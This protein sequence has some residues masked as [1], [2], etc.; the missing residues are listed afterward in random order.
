MNSKQISQIKKVLLRAAVIVGAVLGLGILASP[1]PASYAAPDEPAVTEVSYSMADKNNAVGA[2]LVS[3]L[4]SELKLTVSGA[5]KLV[6]VAARYQYTTVDSEGNKHKVPDQPRTVP[7][8][9]VRQEADGDN[10]KTFRL[11]LD[12]EG[13]YAFGDIRFTLT[14]TD[15]AQKTTKTVDRTLSS[16]IAESKSSPQN[17]SVKATESLQ[18]S[19]VSSFLL[20]DTD[21]GVSLNVT[22]A[23]GKTVDNDATITAASRL[24][25]A[26]VSA[27]V[28]NTYISKLDDLKKAWIAKHTVTVANNDTGAQVQ[29]SGD[30][31]AVSGQQ[32]GSFTVTAQLSKAKEK[33]GGS[34][35]DAAYT[36]K[37]GIGS[38]IGKTSDF[39][40]DTGTPKISAEVPHAEAGRDLAEKVS[41]RLQQANVLIRGSQPKIRITVN[42]GGGIDLKSVKVT[43]KKADSLDGSPRPADASSW[44]QKVSSTRRNRKVIY[45]LTLRDHGLYNLSDIAI[46]A[47]NRAGRPLVADPDGQ[48]LSNSVASKQYDAILVNNGAAESLKPAITVRPSDGNAQPK[49]HNGVKYYR[50][51]VVETVTV[52]DKWIDA[53]RQITG[54]K[55]KVTT[56]AGSADPQVSEIPLTDF[57]F[58]SHDNTVSAAYERKVSDEGRYHVSASLLEG[59]NDEGIEF[60]IDHTA[61]KI[62]RMAVEP[63]G[64]PVWNWLFSDRPVKVTFSGMADHLSGID[65][66]ATGFTKYNGHDADGSTPKLN[67]DDDT[68]SFTLEKNGDR[69]AFADTDITIT[70]FAGNTATFKLSDFVKNDRNE[71][72]YA[73]NIAQKG[74]RGVIVQTEKPVIAVTYDNNSVRNGKYYASGR[75]AT[76][77]ITDPVFDLIVQNDPQRAIVTV[78]HDG[79]STT[80]A[81]EKFTQVPGRQDMWTAQVKCDSDGEWRLSAQLTD[82]SG[83]SADPYETEFIVDATKPSLTLTFDNNR[84][85]NGNYYNANRTATVTVSDRNLDMG[86]THIA[87]TA[88]GDDGRPL[89]AP[90]VSPWAVKDGGAGKDR[91]YTATVTF[92][93]EEHYSISAVSADLAGNASEKV[94]EPEFIIDKTM[95]RLDISRVVDKTAY[96]GAVAP[97]ISSSDSNLDEYGTTYT[98]KSSHNK[99]SSVYVYPK[100]RNTP[101]TQDVTYTDFPHEVKYDDFYTLSATAQDKAGNTVTKTVVFSVNR[102]GSV[103]SFD[104]STQ[105]IRGKYVKKARQ[106]VIRE[107]NVSGLNDN[108]VQANLIKN[109]RVLPLDKSQYSVNNS[110]D[111]GWSLTTYTFPASLFEGNSYYRVQLTSTDKAGNLAQNTMDNKSPNR[112]ADAE[113][114]FAVDAKKPAAAVLGL[115]SNQVYYGPS[116][117]LSLYAR[118]NMATE[119]VELY[120]DGRKV[121]AWDNRDFLSQPPSYTMQADGGNHTVTVKAYDRAGNATETTYGN[122]TIAANWWQ[123]I[124]R[125]PGVLN[126]VIAGTIAALALIAGITVFLVRRHRRR[127]WRRNPF[128]R[129]A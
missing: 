111:K 31:L 90:A 33:L 126:R 46:Q 51:E 88:K 113:V 73:S 72:K 62:S 14:Y 21:K 23:D 54:L 74:V 120:V 55:V 76:V 22:D 17:P 49:E 71:A 117:D 10:T 5:S 95:P 13:I 110:Q 127:K 45:E 26:K 34:F 70:D 93:G 25:G 35:E 106:V 48:T 85:K 96:A 67:I 41:I 114:N 107:T 87:V 57:T 30:D 105:D 102:F 19:G 68:I 97:Q 64:D 91:T 78:G 39:T 66:D 119:R 128:N 101:T 123:Y 43:V 50:G 75:T 24:D 60:V 18:G 32:D 28:S 109:S 82:P 15:T 122:V 12:D 29:L 3:P 47:R 79:G 125:T 44:L 9:E 42:D 59:I 129:L 40:V 63:A 58:T 11:G 92:T 116:H 52:T 56:K 98:L 121:Q 86:S 8:D 4:H 81:A 61:P 89:P 16:L 83:L 124:T 1:A 6:G 53:Y 38:D 77:T 84:S 80:V 27:K 20:T 65:P 99:G 115:S 36:V 112:K 118:D 94:E 104:D 69:L 37:Y 2:Y 108:S 103:Y 7:M 100:V